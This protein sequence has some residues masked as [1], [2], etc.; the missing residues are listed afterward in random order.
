[1]ALHYVI[2]IY[3]KLPCN[4]SHLFPNEILTAT[5]GLH[6]CFLHGSDNILHLIWS[7]YG[8]CQVALCW[9]YKFLDGLLSLGWMQPL[10]YL[11]PCFYMLTIV[12]FLEKILMLFIHLWTRFEAWALIWQSKTMSM[13]FRDWMFKWMLLWEL[14]H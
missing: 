3:N 7:F 1:M 4:L 2:N 14:E 9:F 5:I 11:K 6:F 10:G 8:L 12:S 13:L